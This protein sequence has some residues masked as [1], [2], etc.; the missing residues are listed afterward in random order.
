MPANNQ[1]KKD[2]AVATIQN[3]SSK[4]SQV[5][6]ENLFMVDAKETTTTS[7]QNPL[8]S[9]GVPHLVERRVN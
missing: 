9:R 6:V 4:K 2:L 5:Y 1:K 3:G 7:Y 8:A